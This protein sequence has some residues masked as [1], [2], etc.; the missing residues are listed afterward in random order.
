MKAFRIPNVTGESPEAAQLWELG[1]LGVVEDPGAL[2]AYFDDERPLPLEGT[3]E[4]VPERDYVAEYQAGLEPVRVGRLVVAPSHHE[5]AAKDGDVII[6]LDPGSAFGTGHHETTRL[7]LAALQ[8]RDLR[9]R[10]VL[11]VGSGTGLLTI[12]ADALG[13]RSAYGV[14]VDAA[15]IPV[16][17]QNA[18]RNLSRARFAVGSVDYA[19]LP[20]QFDVV[21][22]NLYAE[23][24]A[25]LMSQ[26]QRRLL[27]GGRLY[28]TGILTRLSHVVTEAVPEGLRLGA[29][30]QDGEW[31]LLELTRTA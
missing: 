1:C 16:A 31:T 18:H 11:D 8:G 23:L 7:A 26:Y 28:L 20:G 12:A 15:T 17:R 6:W 27:P 3:W 10:S 30:V 14:D 21:V 25:Q 29:E 13:A 24:H 19:E 2:V 5:V 9:G 22:A 4:A